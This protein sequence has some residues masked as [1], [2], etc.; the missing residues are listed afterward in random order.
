MLYFFY[1]KLLSLI[2]NMY[3]KFRDV[4]FIVVGEEIV[5]IEGFIVVVGDFNDVVWLFIIRKF[6][7]ISGFLDLWEGCGFFNIFYVKYFLVKWLLDYVFYLEYFVL[8]NIEKFE[9]IGLD[10]YLFYI[11]LVLIMDKE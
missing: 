8:V 1:L 5:E 11:E 9:S 7:K 2:E 4:E 10:Y 6:K 3:V